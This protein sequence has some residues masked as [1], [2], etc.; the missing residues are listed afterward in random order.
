MA[1]KCEYKFSKPL[2]ALPGLLVVANCPVDSFCR[3]PSP[4]QRK[5]IRGLIRCF[6]ASRL[7]WT[8]P[9]TLI[10][11][12]HPTA[13]PVKSSS[14]F[15]ETGKQMPLW[16]MEADTTDEMMHRIQTQHLQARSKLSF[17]LL[18]TASTRQTATALY[19]KQSLAPG[20]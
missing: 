2:L 18:L 16:S 9:S 10:G 13:L 14:H 1:S 6:S 20:A 3:S 7:G 8:H 11:S 19:S 17:K 5:K 4:V 12:L 15:H